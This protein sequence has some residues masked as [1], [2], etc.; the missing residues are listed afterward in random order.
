[1]ILK[2]KDLG[3][4]KDIQNKLNIRIRLIVDQATARS[5]NRNL[6]WEFV[7]NLRTDIMLYSLN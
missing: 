5:F 3:A 4:D 6:E 1:M 7:L 2:N